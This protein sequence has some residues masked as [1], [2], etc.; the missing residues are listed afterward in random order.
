MILY[1]QLQ[2][3]VILALAGSNGVSWSTTY[4]SRSSDQSIVNEAKTREEA[5]TSN[6]PISVQGDMSHQIAE[7]PPPSDHSAIRSGTPF[8]LFSE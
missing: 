7:I 8:L 3:D 6:L 2:A 4:H 1:F 5:W